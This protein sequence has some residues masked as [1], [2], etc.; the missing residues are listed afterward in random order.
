MKKRTLLLPLL[1]YLAACSTASE[2]R[3]TWLAELYVRYLV[4]ESQIKA[5]ATFMAGDSVA[6]ARPLALSGDVRFNGH[7]MGRRQVADKLIRYNYENVGPQPDTVAFAWPHPFRDHTLELRRP[8]PRIDSF[9]LSANGEALQ[10]ALAPPLQPD[11]QVVVMLLD[12]LQRATS[13][14]VVGPQPASFALRTGAN[15]K[16][17]PQATPRQYYLVRKNI[18]IEQIEDGRVTLILETYSELKDL[19]Q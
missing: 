14:T 13:L 10:L 4:P 6:T 9:R 12:S 8:M 15:D 2:E 7:V 17:V 11:E 3:T 19:S 1:L 5:E 16:G 18:R